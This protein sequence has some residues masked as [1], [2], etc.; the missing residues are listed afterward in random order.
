MRSLTPEEK[1]RNDWRWQLKNSPKNI[2]QLSNYFLPLKQEVAAFEK[3]LVSP[4]LPFLATPHYLSLIDPK[5]PHDPLRKQLI[6]NIGEFAKEPAALRDPL[7]EED[8]EPVRHLIHRYPDRVLLFPTDRC[9][10]YCRFCTRKRWVGQ[11]PTPTSD[12][13]ERGFE[14]IE[15]NQQIREI[16]FSGGDTLLLSDSKI[17]YLLKRAREIKHVQIVR[18]GSRMLTFA[19]MRITDE[20]TAILKRYNP[21]Y[22]MTHFNHPNELST[23]ACEALEKL[24]NSGVPVMNQSVLLK[25]I[26]DDASV[27]AE[28]CRKL[29]YLRA[30]P[31]YL[32]Q[33]DVAPGTAHFR[34]PL[35]K[36]QAIVRALRG[37]VSGLC[38]PT[39]VIDI[40]NGHGKVPMHPSPIIDENEDSVLLQGFLNKSAYYPKK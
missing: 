7:G 25:D 38:Q 21:I 9:A 10:S 39:F 18:I 28:L 37:H 12:E 30:K 5:D 27:L 2:E 11:G 20:L 16:I 40:P 1:L 23:E 4:N 15:A 3:L 22:L 29:V 36:A 24:A 31:Y 32:H 26:N 19:P 8:N 14:Y 13:L 34:V 33:C 17:E 6:P 35:D